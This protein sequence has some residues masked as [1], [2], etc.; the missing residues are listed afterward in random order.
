MSVF[1][2]Q[3]NLFITYQNL[4]YYVRKYAKYAEFSEDGRM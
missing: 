4:F 2:E 1:K 3:K